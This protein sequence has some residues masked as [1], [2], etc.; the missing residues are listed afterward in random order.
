M[1][2]A[3]VGS[4]AGTY[5]D[6]YTIIGENESGVRRGKLGVGHFCGGLFVGV[7]DCRCL[8]RCR[9]FGEGELKVVWALH[10]A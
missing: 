4:F 7:F 10:G 1:P 3:H 2:M 5:G 8:W 6:F 9:E